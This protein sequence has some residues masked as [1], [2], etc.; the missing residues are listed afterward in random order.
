MKFEYMIWDYGKFPATVRSN[1]QHL[2]RLLAG[3]KYSQEHTDSRA[4]KALG[5]L[6]E[7]I[8]YMHGVCRQS[9]EN[10]EGFAEESQKCAESIRDHL[11]NG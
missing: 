7:M 1:L 6:D 9:V 10:M 3:D 5:M 11:D 8:S 4:I 2:R